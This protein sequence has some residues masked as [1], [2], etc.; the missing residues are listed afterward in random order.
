MDAARQTADGE[1]LY[2]DA[3]FGVNGVARPAVVGDA[4]APGDGG[5]RP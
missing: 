5:V 1:K 3:T 2:P 4:S